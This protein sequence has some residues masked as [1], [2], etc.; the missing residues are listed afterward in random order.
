MNPEDRNSVIRHIVGALVLVAV[1]LF[2]PI[3]RLWEWAR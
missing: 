2:Y 1:I 3:Y